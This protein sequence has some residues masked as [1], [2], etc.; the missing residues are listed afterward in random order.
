M[1]DDATLIISAISA[2]ATVASVGAVVFFS[3]RSD[4]KERQKDAIVIAEW[5]RDVD[6]AVR[7]TSAALQRHEDECDKR[8][9][10]DKD[11]K[12]RFDDKSTQRAKDLYDH[13]DDR[14]D[15]LDDKISA[16]TTK[17]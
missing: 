8:A 7:E 17:S 6:N 2:A 10:D 9:E 4:R 3:H 11:W 5:R 12:E 1:T 13:I 16:I 14:M 15:R